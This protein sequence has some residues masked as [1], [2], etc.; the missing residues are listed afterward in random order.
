MSSVLSN[1]GGEQHD[2]QVESTRQT[3]IKFTV[4][5]G[6]WSTAGLD[7][8]HKHGVVAPPTDLST[9]NICYDQVKGT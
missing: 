4:A 9:V 8:R 1:V 7:Q 5:V 6:V 3:T 2:P